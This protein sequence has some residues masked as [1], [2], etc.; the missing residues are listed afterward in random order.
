MNLRSRKYTYSAPSARPN[1][2][3]NAHSN[4]APG[5]TSR[6]RIS[7]DVCTIGSA[8]RRIS[9]EIARVARFAAGDTKG[10]TARGKNTLSVRSEASTIDVVELAIELER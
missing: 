7:S 3:Q 6:K 5:M 1:A 10:S 8:T 9:V 2:A 4:A